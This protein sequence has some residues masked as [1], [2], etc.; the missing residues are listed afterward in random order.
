MGLPLVVQVSRPAVPE[1]NHLADLEVCTTNDG[2]SGD[3]IARQQFLPLHGQSCQ[4]LHRPART[5]F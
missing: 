4:C 5:G 2:Q 1:L 3:G